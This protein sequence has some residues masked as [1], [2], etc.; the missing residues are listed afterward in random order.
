MVATVMRIDRVWLSAISWLALLHSIFLWL[1][2]L[3]PPA[4]FALVLR[5]ISRVAAARRGEGD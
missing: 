3:G 1:S 5:G 2:L 4:I